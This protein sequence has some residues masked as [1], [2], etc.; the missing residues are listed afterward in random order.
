MCLDKYC[1]RI[2][3]CMHHIP[4][5]S[6][7]MSSVELLKWA[8][9]EFRG[10]VAFACSFGAEDIVLLHQLSTLSDGHRKSVRVFTLD[11][12]RLPEETYALMEE[13]AERFNIHFEIYFP[14]AVEVERMVSAHGINLFYRS[15]EL[16]KLCCETRKVRPLARALEGM[17]AWITGLRRDQAETRSQVPKVGQDR[18]REGL[19]K[20][21]PL[22]D[23]T[24]KQVWDYIR[25]WHLPYNRL[26]D[27]GYRSIGCAPCTRAVGPWEDERAGRWYWEKGA[28]ECGLHYSMK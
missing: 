22:V 2:M 26:F 11:T 9:D 23:W 25:E 8:C 15:T 16:R 27:R 28:K 5:N 24:S 19:M 18:E 3:Q 13:A 17:E 20:I 1:S 7:E 21:C 14:D 10:K 4:E 6:E 12:G